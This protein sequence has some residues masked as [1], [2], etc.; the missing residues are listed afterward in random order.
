[1]SRVFRTTR[2]QAR[3]LEDLVLSCKEDIEAGKW[4]MASFAKWAG[5]KL[6][7][8]LKPGHVKGAADAVEVA[9]VNRGGYGGDTRSLHA[10]QIQ[11]I[12]ASV[13]A[14]AAEVNRILTELEVGPSREFI[15][16]CADLH[17]CDDDAEYEEEEDD[18]GRD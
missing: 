14:V 3:Q 13:T 9:F 5:R 1:M 4:T 7:L 2:A 12:K 6:G 18:C 15:E 11:K 17:V 16:A 8:P 10:R